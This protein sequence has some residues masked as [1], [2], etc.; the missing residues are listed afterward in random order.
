MTTKAIVK[1]LNDAARNM[2]SEVIS[3]LSDL[4]YYPEDVVAFEAYD[5]SR[6]EKEAVG[7]T[8]L[9][10]NGESS[11]FKLELVDNEL[12]FPGKTAGETSMELYRI[13]APNREVQNVVER[14]NEDWDYYQSPEA[15]EPVELRLAKEKVTDLDNSIKEMSEKTGI[16]IPS[17]NAYRANPDKLNEARFKNVIALAYFY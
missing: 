14:I 13:F 9:R 15:L 11:R 2:G 7:M 16:S 3:R 17:L 8:I 6:G 4:T 12:V 5:S 1:A 10:G